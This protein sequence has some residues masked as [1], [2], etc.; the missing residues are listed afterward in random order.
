M[1][2]IGQFFGGLTDTDVTEAGNEAALRCSAG[3]SLA[4]ESHFTLHF[5]LYTYACTWRLIKVDPELSCHSF[6]QSP[7]HIHV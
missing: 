3:H 7:A 5:L 6:I 4:R 1:G 2:H